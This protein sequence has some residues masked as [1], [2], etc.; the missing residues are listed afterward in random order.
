MAVNN[1]RRAAGAGS[2]FRYGAKERQ[3]AKNTGSLLLFHIAKIVFPLAVLPYL[4]RTLS[5]QVYGVVAYVRTVMIY[6]QIIVDFGFALSATKDIVKTQDDRERMS[7]VIGDT[8][9]AKIIL[10]IAGG[11]ALGVLCGCLPILKGN[12]L[13]TFLS[14]LVVLESVFLMDFVFRGL[15]IMHVIT[16]RFVAMKVFSTGLTFVFVRDDTDILW[17]PL[18]DIVSSILAIAL[19]FY[20]LK[21]QKIGIQCSGISKAFSMIKE[22]FV[23]FLSNVASTSFNALSTL[24]I[25]A[26]ISA[27]E[28]AYWSVC[29]QII[30][31]IQ[32]C[33]SPISDGIYPE[34]VRSAN[35]NIL[36]RIL[37]L[38]VPIVCLGCIAAYLLAGKG[39]Y[40]LGGEKYLVAVPVFRILIPCLFFGFLSMMIGWPVLGAIGKTKETTITTVASVCSHILMLAVLIV[41]DQFTLVNIAIV[42]CLTD[43]LMFVMRFLFYQKYKSLFNRI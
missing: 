38:C 30:G 32:A 25:G 4:T 34:M 3:L 14:Y 18:L 9:L 22:S 35:I 27:T 28:V 23:F 11:M 31:S 24:M 17:I 15:E 41:S 29:M 10:G 5:T 19:V 43:I 40:L 37:R 12:L 1:R 26:Y 7:A 36:K 21:K 8:L 42:R 20:E 39:M 2:L 33:Y 13:Y 6:M 16:V